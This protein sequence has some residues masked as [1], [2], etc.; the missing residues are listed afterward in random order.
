MV[1]DKVAEAFEHGD[2]GTSVLGSRLSALGCRASGVGS[3]GVGEL[4]EH[5]LF[6][7]DSLDP[8]PT[9]DSRQPTA[10]SQELSTH[11]INL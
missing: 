10:D 3:W 2:D 9:A 4:G 6:F 11:I 1:G 8:C 5:G 7:S